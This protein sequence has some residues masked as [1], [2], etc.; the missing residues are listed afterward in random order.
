M[1]FVPTVEDKERYKANRRQKYLENTEYRAKVSE[2][3]KDWLKQNREKYNETRRFKWAN[4]PE[5]RE[6]LLA[7]RRGKCQRGTML[8][9]HYGITIDEYKAMEAAQ[10]FVCAICSQPAED[11]LCVDHCHSTSKV[12]GLLCRKCNT[13]LGCFKDN[14]ELMVKAM[15]Y[16]EAHREH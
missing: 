14:P 12:R 5:H 4:D 7:P 2:R 1:A 10:G 9:V 15:A 3:N 8:K 6:K 11:T 16:L 13:G